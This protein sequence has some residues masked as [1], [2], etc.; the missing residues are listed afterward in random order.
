ML[1]NVS[2][3]LERCRVQLRSRSE[4]VEKYRKYT[5]QLQDIVKDLLPG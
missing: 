3:E 2:N 1:Q 4:E 5:L